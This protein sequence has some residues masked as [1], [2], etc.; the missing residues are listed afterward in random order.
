VIAGVLII[1]MFI[2]YSANL[3]TL[4]NIS[5]ALL[6]AY[7]IG[8]F[9]Y[10]IAKR[11]L[12]KRTDPAISPTRALDALLR[13]ALGMP[14]RKNDVARFYD[15]KS[16]AAFSKALAATIVPLARAAGIE[17]EKWEMSLEA[18]PR[19]AESAM[20]GVVSMPA[21]AIVTASAGEN[22]AE[23]LVEGFFSFV[24]TPGGDSLAVDPCPRV[25]G[26]V[27]REPRLREDAPSLVAWERCESCGAHISERY[28][29]AIGGCP[30]CAKASDAADCM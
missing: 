8:I 4:A 2:L 3:Y 6:C 30:A 18:N 9:S 7:V 17:P 25:L 16:V 23:F 1:I 12:L 21:V 24:S 11:V 26:S 5:A 27:A 29:K 19:L 10:I 13:K 28:K 15:E 20:K 14:A 22:S